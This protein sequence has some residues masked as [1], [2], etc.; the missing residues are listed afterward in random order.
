MT[1]K[2]AMIGDDP[3]LTQSIL[4]LPQFRR[5][6]QRWHDDPERMRSLI[7]LGVKLAD[8]DYYSSRL[9]G[10]VAKTRNDTSRT[11]GRPVTVARWRAFSRQADSFV[12]AVYGALDALAQIAVAVG[13]VRTEEEVKFPALAGL[14]ASGS[15]NPERW[16]AFRGWLEE[17]YQA[18]WFRELRRLRNLVNYRSVLG[19]PLEGPRPPGVALD[20]ATT[21]QHVVATVEAGL[22]LL[23]DE[24]S[25]ES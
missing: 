6:S 25:G 3:R 8:A 2:K 16:V 11:K 13:R 15:Q 18:G 20:W 19:P 1:G 24:G 5:A 23:L 21:Y 10:A 7:F 17:V 9:T 12:F 22:G 14:L 4:R